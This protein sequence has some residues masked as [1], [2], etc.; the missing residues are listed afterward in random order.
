MDHPKL[1]SATEKIAAA[2]RNT[3][4]HWGRPCATLELCQQYMELG[5]RL[6]FHQCDLMLVKNG[7]EKIQ[8]DFAPLG[9]S[10]EK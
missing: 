4:K 8:R 7:L 10:F 3:G 2:A 1:Q 9:F 5:A 6:I